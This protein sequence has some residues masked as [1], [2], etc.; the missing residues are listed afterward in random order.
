MLLMLLLR[1]CISG[2]RGWDHSAAAA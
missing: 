1:W 2:A